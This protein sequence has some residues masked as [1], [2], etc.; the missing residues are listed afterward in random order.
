MTLQKSEWEVRDVKNSDAVA[1]VKQYHYSGGCS[2]T[3][4]YSHGLFRMGSAELMG[5]AVWLPPTG[6][7]ARSVNLDHWQKVL[8]L[9]RLA[10]HPNVP[11]NGATFLMSR[12][13]KMIKKDGRFISLVTYADTRMGHTGAIYRASNWL[14]VGEMKGSPAWVNALTGRQVARK[15]TTSR[16][17]AEMVALGYEMVGVFSKHK[18]VMHLNS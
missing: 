8:S 2:N 6:P 11:K 12:S 1:F 9:S 18:F 10:I 13:I 7:A 14:Y 15:A 16:T 5:V 3:R 4:V 17:N